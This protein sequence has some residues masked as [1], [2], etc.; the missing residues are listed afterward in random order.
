M[1]SFCMPSNV[2]SEM[3]NNDIQNQDITNSKASFI[4]C[5]G[6]YFMKQYV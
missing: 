2:T 3:I 6:I 5:E 4:D 1:S